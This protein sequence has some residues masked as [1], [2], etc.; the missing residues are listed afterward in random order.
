MYLVRKYQKISL[1][2]FEFYGKNYR[3]ISRTI[4]GNKL[5]LLVMYE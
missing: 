5:I 1:N 2:N 3:R 4:L